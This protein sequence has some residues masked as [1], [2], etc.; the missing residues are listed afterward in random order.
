MVVAAVCGGQNGTGTRFYP[1]RRYTMA[2]DSD[3]Q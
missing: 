3:I 2:I 1:I